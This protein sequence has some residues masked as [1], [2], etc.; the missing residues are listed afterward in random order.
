MTNSNDDRIKKYVKEY[1]AMR[2]WFDIQD[3]DKVRFSITLDGLENARLDV[4][5]KKIGMKKSEFVNEAIKLLVK[6]FES[7]LKL[8]LKNNRDH[9]EEIMETYNKQN[10]KFQLKNP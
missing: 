1:L 10:K 9:W 2:E 5:I 4:L 6:E 7:Q 3:Q 8:D